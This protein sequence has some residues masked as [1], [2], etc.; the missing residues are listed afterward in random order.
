[1]LF[2]NMYKCAKTSISV[3]WFSGLYGHKHH[4]SVVYDVNVG[5]DNVDR[6]F[7]VHVW[8]VEHTLK[9]INFEPFNIEENFF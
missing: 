4:T 6:N 1:M 3:N 5:R 9:L 2:P 8:R 7:T